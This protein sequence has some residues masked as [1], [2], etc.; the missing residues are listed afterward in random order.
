MGLPLV[1]NVACKQMVF[2]FPSLIVA[3]Q[4]LLIKIDEQ[5]PPLKAELDIDYL[6]FMFNRE[7]LRT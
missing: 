1:P 6:V 2:S 4:F 5:M 7:M 3:L